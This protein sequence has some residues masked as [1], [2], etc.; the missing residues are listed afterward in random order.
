MT[1]SRLRDLAPLVCAALFVGA[2]TVAV[3]AVVMIASQPIDHLYRHLVLDDAIYYVQPA[4]NVVAGN[5]YSF[6]GVHRTNG[7]QPLWAGIVLV[8]T[9]LLRAPE[10]VVRAM[11]LVGGLLHVV[12]AGLVFRLLA[13]TGLFGA[14]LGAVIVLA[15]G[16]DQRLSVSGMEVGLHCLLLA[17][18]LLLARNFAH[19][20]TDA[21]GRNGALIRLGV[22]AALLA[23][24]RVEYGLFAALLGVWL[25]WLQR[26]AG[27]PVAALRATVPYAAPL[28][29]IGV[30]WL[31][32]SKVYF[33]EW[34]PVSGS[35]KA[36]VCRNDPR[37]LGDRLVEMG[38]LAVTRTFPAEQ[39]G[40]FSW[41]SQWSGRFATPGEVQW[42]LLAL[43]S[44]L[45]LGG[46][47][48]LRRLRAAAPGRTLGLAVV[49]LLF[50]ATHLFLMAK[51]LAPFA[52]YCAWYMTGEIVAIGAL[53]GALANGL[54]GWWRVAALPPTALLAVVLVLAT[55][56]WFTAGETWVTSPFVDAGRFAA[57]WL[58]RGS[59]IGCFASGYIALTNPDNRVV[60]LDGLIND[61]R[62]LRDYVMRDRIAD[63]FRD[64]RI[65]YFVD[66]MPAAQWREHLEHRSRALP[67]SLQLIHCWPETSDTVAGVVATGVGDPTL[68][69]AT[70]HP[71]GALHFAAFVRGEHRV[72][73]EPARA[74]LPAGQ[75]IVS[76][77]VVGAEQVQHVAV[78]VERLGEV[79][80][81]V[82]L[83]ALPACDRRFGDALSL[84]A[85]DAPA[86]PLA[87]GATFAVTTYWQ[88]GEGIGAG[89][90]PRLRLAIG[91][92]VVEEAPLHGT[93]PL[94]QWPVGTVVPHTF[95]V[96]LPATMPS[97]EHRVEVDV[98]DARGRPMAAEGDEVPHVAVRV[99][100]D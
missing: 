26:P 69:A 12:G 3:V 39:L 23:L 38:E 6:D 98:R 2:C 14:L 93:L 58:P 34:T 32:F 72:V 54:R 84:R 51:V 42:T 15:A 61:G 59:T 70:P 41:L 76:S 11:V 24:T 44:P 92:V 55:P 64:E 40:L 96:T 47:A 75:V 43:L 57:R 52:G 9:M 67:E 19:R 30:T 36:W 7:V 20:P 17:L 21:P 1:P 97:G 85:I 46:A 78:A 88:A 86:D 87:P 74:Q 62:Y 99:A 89:P 66:C 53:C 68:P 22:V 56:G 94:G 60:N 28:L 48:L 77:S 37:P 95:V 50:L 82:G 100:A 83:S 81:A 18:T 13:P 27:G 91:P 63:Y 79:V 16:M 29:A 73:P 8:M 45:L 49:L 4:R 5:G 90:L 71:L 25:V 65:G 31:V 10:S 33:G 80:D 35:L